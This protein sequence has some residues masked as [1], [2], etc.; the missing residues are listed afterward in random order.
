MAIGTPYTPSECYEFWRDNI[1]EEYKTYVKDSIVTMM[2][3]E[4][5]VQV[6][7]PWEHPTRG[8]VMVRFSGRR[9]K[10]AG[11]T[12]ILEGYCRMISDVTGA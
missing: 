3:S 8:N 12:V 4:K 1:H 10:D 11:S 9:G 2:Q 5:A 7:F 6:E